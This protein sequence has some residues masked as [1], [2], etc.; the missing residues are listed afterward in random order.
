MHNSLPPV[1]FSP[2]QGLGSVLLPDTRTL[3][4]CSY[5][6]KDSFVKGEYY[7]EAQNQFWALMSGVLDETLS[8]K[9]YE[10]RLMV[11]LSY[12]IG[13][14]DVISACQSKGSLKG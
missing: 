1:P 14:W 4:L 13:L 9:T 6:G 2:L 5:P 8:E 3:L 12:G 7:A 10:E 11:L